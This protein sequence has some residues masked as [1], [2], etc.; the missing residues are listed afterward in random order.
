M[1]QVSL[2]ECLVEFDRRTATRKVR[3]ILDN[4][5]AHVP[6]SDLPQRI[7]LRST[8]NKCV[9]LRI[10]S[11]LPTVDLRIIRDLKAYFWCSSYVD[12]SETELNHP[13]ELADDPRV[14]KPRSGV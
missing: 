2:L 7:A 1:T 12:F 3:L 9:P 10:T 6:L 5:S 8:I 13:A 14:L 4:C 11:K